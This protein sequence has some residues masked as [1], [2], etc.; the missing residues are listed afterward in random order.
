MITTDSPMP[1]ERLSMHRCT[2]EDAPFFLD[3]LTSRLWIQNIGDRGV[4][5]LTD[6]R[7]YI[8]TK[9]MPGYK[10]PGLG[11]WLVRLNDGTPIGCVGVYDRPGLELPDFG[12]AF[13]EEYHGQGY[14]YEAAK[15][16]MAYARRAGMTE[17]LAITLPTNLPSIRLLKKLGF[18][19]GEIVDIPNDPA[20][21]LKLRWIISDE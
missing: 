2:E 11:N 8:R 10:R 13:L 21:L 12:F 19:A 17:L 9:V 4:Y 20:P 15:S 7:R 14:A 18:V 1:T 16:G 5:N 6:A 3:L